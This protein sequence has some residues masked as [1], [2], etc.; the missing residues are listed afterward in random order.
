[1]PAYNP[2]LQQTR[3]QMPGQVQMPMPGQ[4]QG[5]QQAVPAVGM[6]QPPATQYGYAQAPGGPM[7]YYEQQTPVG[8]FAAANVN[9]AGPAQTASNPYLGQT[10]Q[11]AGGSA[12][13]A[14]TTT[15]PYFGAGNPYTSQAVDAASQAATRNYN[16]AIAPQR[17]AQMARSGSFG[18]TGVQ[19]MQM[20]DQRNLQ[21]TL[22]N[23][24]TNAYMQDLQAQQQMGE[25]AANRGTSNSQFNVG[26]RAGD[27]NRNMQGTQFDAGLAAQ[28]GMFNAGQ[29]NQ[30]GQFNA[31]QGNQMNMF[32]AT[33]GNSML[34][35]QRNLG[36]QQNQFDQ[37]FDFQA[38]LA[39]N[40]QQR[41]GTQD[42]LNFMDRLMNWQSQ[43]VGAATNVQNTPLNY[44]Q[45]FNSGAAQLG[46]MGGTNSQV[47][48]GNP[49]LGALGGAQVGGTLYNNWGN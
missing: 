40:N 19:Q 17:D 15:N 6:G 18:N 38:W 46:G 7:G 49:W 23:I 36:Q 33:A 29:A 34:N 22:G 26:A 37:N 11:M 13:Q 20:E 9:Q 2:Y 14:S 47:N 31:G 16:L 1:M 45:M 42:Q 48:Q 41:L 35:Q 4:T 43:G 25:S 39:N 28:Q 21:G 3:P 24:A 44:W 5:Q 8:S 30:M 12:G 32:N 27:L 10:S